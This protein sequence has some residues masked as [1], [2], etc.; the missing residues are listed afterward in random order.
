ME[1]RTCAKRALAPAFGLVCVAFGVLAT[2]CTAE[3][4]PDH[5]SSSARILDGTSSARH[6]VVL[7]TGESGFVACSGSLV[8]PDVVLTAAHCVPSVR[9]AYVGFSKALEGATPVD[10]IDAGSASKRAA[11]VATAIAPGYVGG[12]CPAVGSDVALLRLSAQLAGPV[13]SFGGPP[14][15]GAACVVV[16]FGRHNAEAYP[17]FLES[18][19]DDNELAK[20][21]T[22]EQRAARVRIVERNG[23]T[24]FT[25]TGLDGAHAQGDSGG[26]I[27]C[28]GH[29]VGVASCT[30]QRHEAILDLRKVYADLGPVRG[31]LDATLAS[32]ATAPSD[33]GAPP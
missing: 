3:D 23:E 22:G 7:L 20:F 8:A 5:A 30:W 10:T 32:W 16:G 31:F 29:Q 13:V 2:G 18:D 26:P 19:L 11:V 27:F 1:H 25:A 6:D 33:A 12:R 28:G 9:F 17:G 21:T 24:A 4:A 15:V 14:A